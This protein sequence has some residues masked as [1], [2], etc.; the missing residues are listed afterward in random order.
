[1]QT[2]TSGPLAG[3]G[4]RNSPAA[5]QLLLTSGQRELGPCRGSPGTWGSAGYSPYAVLHAALHGELSSLAAACH[6]HQG[7][8]SRLTA[9]PAEGMLLFSPWAHTQ[10]EGG[11]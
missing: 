5:G 9:F 6:F 3:V 7:W 10:A 11:E 8:N 4:Q 2:R 1:M